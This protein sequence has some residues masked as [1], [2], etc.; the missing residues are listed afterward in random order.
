MALTSRGN[1]E[2]DERM[3]RPTFGLK[4]HKEKRGGKGAPAKVHWPL[5]EA[6]ACVFMWLG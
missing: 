4:A 6:C 3:M 2:V 5:D 1:L